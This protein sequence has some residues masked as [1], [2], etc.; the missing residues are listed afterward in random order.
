MNDEI[1]TGT[2]QYHTIDKGR[3][4]N[5]NRLQIKTKLYVL[6][7]ISS[8]MFQNTDYFVH[9]EGFYHEII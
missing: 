8:N 7:S 3:H 6:L 2:G 5:W 1:S 4:S 9:I